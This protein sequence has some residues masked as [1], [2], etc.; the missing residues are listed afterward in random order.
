MDCRSYQLD[1]LLDRRPHWRLHRR[2]A[3]PL[4]R[5]TR[6][7]LRYS[8]LPHCHSHR[9][10]IRKVMARPFRRTL[11]H[12]HWYRCKECHSTYLQCRDG[13]SPY[14][15]SACHV[16]ATLGC[17]WHLLRFLRKHNRERHWRH[18]VATPTGFCFHPLIHSWHGNLLLP[19]GNLSVPQNG[20]MLL[21]RL[22]LQ[23]G[24]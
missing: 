9:L 12:G 1:Y 10:W 11:R 21:T 15:R 3:Q 14:S 5:S 17:Y 2:P 13:P 20:H 23:D 7:N 8:S 19:R 6:R 16:L 4:P 24:S 18:C 22:S